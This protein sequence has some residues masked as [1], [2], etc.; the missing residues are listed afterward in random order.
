[1]SIAEKFTET[2]VSRLHI[3]N[4]AKEGQTDTCRGSDVGRG[5]VYIAETKPSDS[6]FVSNRASMR[7]AFLEKAVVELVHKF[8][9]KSY[10]ECLKR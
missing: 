5:E 10:C 2:Q 6:R 7:K 1:M 8:D 9:E 4:G 3:E